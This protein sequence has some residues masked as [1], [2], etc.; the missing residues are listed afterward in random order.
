MSRARRSVSFPF[1]S[2]PHWVPT[3][4]VA[5]TRLPSGSTS[6]ILLAG[7]SDPG[8]LPFGASA[9]G[10]LAAGRVDAHGRP[11]RVAALQDREGQRITDLA[12]DDSADRPGT[13]LGVV[14][15]LGDERLRRR[16]Q[17]DREVTGLEPAGEDTE[18]DV[19]DRDDVW[20][21]RG[22]GTARSRRSG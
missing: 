14:A 11:V 19:D 5:G 4:T 7:S 10:E 18:L 12:L 15:E 1:P 21:G 17:L 13:E 2:S 3:T 9:E 16:R 6:P 8:I 20:R 22:R